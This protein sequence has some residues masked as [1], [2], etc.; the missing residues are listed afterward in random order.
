MLHYRTMLHFSADTMDIS[1][2][3]PESWHRAWNRRS[4]FKTLCFWGKTV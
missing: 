1:L 2:K 4:A 3:K